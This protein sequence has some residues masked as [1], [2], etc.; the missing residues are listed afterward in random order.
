MGNIDNLTLH[1]INEI[2]TYL[3]FDVLDGY[4]NY[5]VNDKLIDNYIENRSNTFSFL[6][7]NQALDDFRYSKSE[8][9]S[10]Y[11]RY[12]EYAKQLG[13]EKRNTLMTQ[14]EAN[15]LF[16]ICIRYIYIGY[17]VRLSVDTYRFL[18]LYIRRTSIKFANKV[19]EPYMTDNPKDNAFNAEC[20]SEELRNLIQVYGDKAKYPIYIS[21]Y[22]TYNANRMIFDFLLSI[23]TQS[24]RKRMSKLAML[25]G[26]NSEVRAIAFL[27]FAIT[28]FALI[29]TNYELIY[30]D[31]KKLKPI[32]NAADQYGYG[33]EQF[34]KLLN[35]LVKK[36]DRKVLLDRR[37]D[38]TYIT[39]NILS[40]EMIMKFSRTQLADINYRIKNKEPQYVIDGVIK[41]YVEQGRDSY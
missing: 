1:V 29:N 21:D 32:L 35:K 22:G 20:L 41:R 31:S 11:N 26:Y 39:R 18:N 16:D 37:R 33:T 40:D 3:K 34:N 14:D 19:F 23:R 10:V 24:Y 12:L 2:R 28:A 36:T 13:R 15:K 4:N 38:Y 9:M 6:M 27:E 17:I 5:G 8:R 25:N 30:L 7:N